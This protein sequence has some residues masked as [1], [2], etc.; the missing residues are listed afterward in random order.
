[1]HETVI[2]EGRSTTEYATAKS[3]KVWGIVG[4]LLGGLVAFG[5]KLLEALSGTIGESS[6]AYAIAGACIATAAL[7]CKT[8]AELGY[9]KS[10]TDT[11][12]AAADL[13]AAKELA[14]LNS[15]EL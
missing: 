14:K 15:P 1:M 11:K 3:A 2:K 12:V 10:R 5:P 8:L 4:M 13:D 6:P 7:M 9:I